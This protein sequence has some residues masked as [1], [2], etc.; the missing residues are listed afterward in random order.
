MKKLFTSPAFMIVIS[1]AV[2]FG[3]T[4]AQAERQYN[5]MYSQ[6]D[7]LN[8]SFEQFVRT[9]ELE[10]IRMFLPLSMRVFQFKYNTNGNVPAVVMVFDQDG[11]LVLTETA[12]KSIRRAE[13]LQ[14]RLK[15]ATENEDVFWL[16]MRTGGRNDDTFDS[17]INNI[18]QIEYYAYSENAF[19]MEE[20]YEDAPIDVESESGLSYVFAA[21]AF[22]L[23]FVLRQLLPVY[24]LVAL[25]LAALIM[26]RK[27]LPREENSNTEEDGA[28]EDKAAD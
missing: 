21:E 9:R 15:E 25:L 10:D 24:L 20:L 13:R 18:F 11:Q 2:L 14:K 16:F 3:V 23:S 12:G 19:L 6:I 5:T 1:I 26:T 27:K 28:S 7:E 8:S 4:A 17:F 22:P